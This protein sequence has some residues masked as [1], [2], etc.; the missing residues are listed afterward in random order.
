MVYGT[1]WRLRFGI[2]LAVT[3]LCARTPLQAQSLF[4]GVDSLFGGSSEPAANA[5]AATTGALLDNQQRTRFV[6]GLPKATSCAA[7]PK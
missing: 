6:I 5:Q 2:L 4:D 7:A 3:L 1:P